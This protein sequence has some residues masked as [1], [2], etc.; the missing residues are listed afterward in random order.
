MPSLTG[1]TLPTGFPL[2]ASQSS[3]LDIV[4]NHE[5]SFSACVR[6][7]SADTP[8]FELWPK[9]S[10]KQS[11]VGTLAQ[12]EQEMRR[13]NSRMNCKQEIMMKQCAAVLNMHRNPSHLSLFVRILDTVPAKILHQVLRIAFGLSPQ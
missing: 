4:E 13:P 9:K 5:E 11:L 10:L 6:W 7:C 1:V 3:K 8:L 2:D 12:V